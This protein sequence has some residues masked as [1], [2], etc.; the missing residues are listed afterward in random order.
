M[1]GIDT[2]VFWLVFVPDN[3][4]NT[5]LTGSYWLLTMCDFCSHLVSPVKNL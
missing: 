3:S 4:H 1:M 5:A 2:V